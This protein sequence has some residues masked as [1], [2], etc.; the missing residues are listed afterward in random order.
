MWPVNEPLLK[1]TTKLLSSC[2]SVGGQ[3]GWKFWHFPAVTFL[4]R[5]T[6]ALW[7]L[8]MESRN[9]LEW[10]STYSARLTLMGQKLTLCIVFFDTKVNSWTRK[11]KLWGRSLG[12]L[13][14]FLLT[15][16]AKLSSTFHLLLTCNNFLVMWKTI[17]RRTERKRQRVEVESLGE[18]KWCRMFKN[19]GHFDWKTWNYF[20]ITLP[21]YIPK[22]LKQIP[23]NFKTFTII[24]RPLILILK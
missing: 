24:F 21:P 22:K 6:L 10:T 1:T 9:C 17:W 12:T 20:L 7:K 13:L 2:M 5:S 11:K 3:K 16:K 8:K 14:S 23:F 4:I 18:S 15:T 19:Q